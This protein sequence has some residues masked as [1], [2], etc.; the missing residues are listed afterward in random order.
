V[1]LL[2]QISDE[3]DHIKQEMEERGSTMTDGGKSENCITNLFY[4][5]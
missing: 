5:L 2:E 3:L 1:L 4:E